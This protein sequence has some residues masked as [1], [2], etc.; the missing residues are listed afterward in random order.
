MPADPSIFSQYL[1]PVRSIQDYGADMDKR[2]LLALQL[3]GQQGQNALL[4]LTRQQQMETA[5]Q[6][7]QKQQAMQAIYADPRYKDPIAR[8]D[9]MVNDARLAA[10]GYA[11]RKA[12][13]EI[14]GLVAKSS[15]QQSVAEKNRQ[16]TRTAAI[17][18]HLQQIPLLKST[19]LAQQWLAA[20]VP[21]GALTQ[22]QATHYMQN[23]PGQN[24]PLPEIVGY[25]QDLQKLGLTNL[26]QIELRKPVLGG[27]NLGGMF[28]Y[29]ARNPENGAVTVNGNAPMSQTPESIATNATTRYTAGLTDAR[30]RGK[31][32]YETDGNG[33]L[34]ALPEIAA[35]GS[36]IKA[37]AVTAPGP[38][39]VPMQGKDQTM[40]EGQAKALSFGSRMT[41]ARGV[42]EEMEKKGVYNKG[43][44]KAIAQSAGRVAGLGTDSMGGTLAD[45]AGNLT[46]GS[47]S[48]EQQRY[49][50]AKQNWIAANLRKESGASIAANEYR[51]AD[52]QYFPQPGD[53]AGTKADKVRRRRIAEDTMLAEVPRGK[54]SAAAP[55][56]PKPGAV[57]KFDAQ[58]NL[59]P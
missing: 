15:E 54:R 37:G 30:E 1:S 40:N 25:L 6:G 56:A 57:L 45:I 59:L 10:D 19:Q 22:Q 34:V 5:R 16:E 36:I 44:I 42:I 14:E 47:Q 13:L 43:A 24:A 21:V 48:E 11:A 23:M 55:A 7:M 8:E 3:Q 38:G 53:D 58:G 50:A 52:N 27:Q 35:P 32:K 31:V 29:T 28:Q 18:Q 51:D 46:N 39:M 26:Q 33:N 9:A 4:D 2:N 17:Q 49:E 20:A 41:D 12:R